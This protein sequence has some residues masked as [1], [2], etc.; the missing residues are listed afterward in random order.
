MNNHHH[1]I[2]NK[3]GD[4]LRILKS[5]C[6]KLEEYD[7]SQTRSKVFVLPDF[8]VDR[9]IE[10][11]NESLFFRDV[12]RKIV[13]GGGSMRGYI[14]KDIKGGNAVNVAYCLA[15]LGLIIELCTVS[16]FVGSAILKSVFS[17]FGKNVKLQ[18]VKGKHGLSSV[19]EFAFSADSSIVSP[20]LPSPSSHPLD[21]QSNTPPATA[22]KPSFA[23]IMISDV[24]DNDNFGPELIET[25]ETLKKLKVAQ[26][27]VFTNWA[28]NYRGTDLMKFVFSKS[29]QS[30]HFIDPADFELRSFEFVNTLKNNSD[31]IDIL[32]IN[33]N[34][35]NHIVKA[36]KDIS[37]KKD[38]QNLWY[39]YNTDD[40]L[41]NLNNFCTTA[42]FIYNY[43]GIRLCIH[44]TKGS[45]LA[46]NRCVTFVSALTPPEIN[47]VSGA[48]DSWDAGFIFGE[49]AGFT[50]EEKLAFANLLAMLHIDNFGGDDPSLEQVIGYLKKL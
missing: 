44:T 13:A 14:S 29:P 3:E 47:I 1:S 27:V 20:D 4:T 43:L 12:K 45:I 42:E 6:T 19:F 50:S 39:S 25:Q 34:E 22:I 21:R 37:S 38:G 9:I 7:K 18:V 17:S 15:K 28:S 36:L 23:N 32:S 30:I 40:L 46:D 11:T 8:F 10:V 49:L 35:Y 41:D 31:L 26:A 16:D 2:Y 48:G 5:L 33:E 24:G